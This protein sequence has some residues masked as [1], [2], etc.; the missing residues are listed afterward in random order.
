[1]KTWITFEIQDYLANQVELLELISWEYVRKWS[2]ELYEANVKHLFP[3]DL[4]QAKLINPGSYIWSV[5]YDWISSYIWEPT[6]NQNIN[7]IDLYEWLLTTW[8]IRFFINVDTKKLETIK[9]KNYYY[10]SVNKKEYFINIYEKNNENSFTSSRKD[11]YLLVETFSNNIFERNLYKLNSISNLA[12]WDKV[13][14]D[15]LDFLKWLPESV[16]IDFTNGWDR[17]VIE[18][19]VERPL[20]EKLKTII[21]SIEKKLSEIDKNFLDYTE[22][23]KVFR[24]L[25]IPDDCFRELVNWVKVVDF[26][27]LWK[28]IMTND[29]NWTSWWLDIVRNTN[30]LLVESIDYI[31]SQIRSISSISSVPLFAFGIKNEWWNDSWTSKIKSAWLFYK[32]V[33]KYQN[34]ITKLFY[35]FWKKLAIPESEQI[36]EFWDIVTSDITEVVETQ[37][38]MLEWWVQSKKR[39]I[40]KLNNTD[41]KDA[42]L[43]LEEIRKE[44]E[45]DILLNKN[46]ETWV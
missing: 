42:E 23:F 20:L 26:D 18:K 34:I 1:M 13:S 27:K 38:K 39:A 32:K 30:D 21:F 43:I 11:F 5:V 45:Q 9:A 10:D 40:M 41:D 12:E 2:W 31:D 44:K 3:W 29:L 37:V 6:E 36:L 46:N 24:N 17:L 7:Y 35:E 16:K 8:Y 22:Q 15:E 25:D 14:F 19:Q 33:E 4:N 28:V